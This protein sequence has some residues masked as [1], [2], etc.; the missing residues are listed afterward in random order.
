MISSPISNVGVI[1]SGTMGQ[2]I[3]QA[4]LMAGYQVF[5]FD[6]GLPLTLNASQAIDKS[7]Q[8]LVDKGKLSAAVKQQHLDNLKT[9]N[10]LSDIRVDLIIEAVIENLEIKQN[11]FRQLEEINSPQTILT[12]NTSSLSIGKICVGLRERQ[13]FAGL[14]FFNPAPLMK[15]VEIVQAEMTSSH[16]VEVLR[17]FCLSLQKLPVLV[18]DSPGFIVNRVARLYY[19]EALRLLEEGAAEVESIDALMRNSGFRMG[20]FELMDLIGIDTNLAVTQSIYE[21]FGQNPKFKPSAIQQQKVD[22]KQLGRKTGKGF[23]EYKL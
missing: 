1:G 5:L 21:A 11:I 7:F 3:A 20:P 23:Y 17:S 22:N 12:S 4:C 16:T 9:S 14:H 18:K 8:T 6:I 15:L 19:V 13:R 2:G 10:V